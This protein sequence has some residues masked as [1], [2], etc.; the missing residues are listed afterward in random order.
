MNQGA[1]FPDIVIL[2]SRYAP[3]TETLCCCFC[4][5]AHTSINFYNFEKKFSRE[6]TKAQVKKDFSFGYYDPTL[7]LLHS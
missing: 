1:V 6:L 7:I 5:T 4:F 2:S 3:L